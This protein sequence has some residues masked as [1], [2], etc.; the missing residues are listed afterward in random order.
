MSHTSQ[1]GGSVKITTYLC[2]YNTRLYIHHVGVY[3]QIYGNLDTRLYIHHV[4]VHT[5]I[6][7][8]LDKP[9]SP[10]PN[11]SADPNSKLV[12]NPNPNPISLTQ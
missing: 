6:Y 3:T 11:P 1:M 2:T 4:S 10:N 7:G 9:L 8:N 5:Q 12:P